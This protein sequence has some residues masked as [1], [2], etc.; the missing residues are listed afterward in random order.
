VLHRPVETAPFVR[1][2][3]PALHIVP[4]LLSF[5]SRWP[6]IYL[7]LYCVAGSRMGLLKE[8]E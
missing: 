2:W 1:H 3:Q 6:S 8:F 7:L 4:S 5:I